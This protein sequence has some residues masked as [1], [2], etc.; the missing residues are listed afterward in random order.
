M[1][2]RTSSWLRDDLSPSRGGSGGPEPHSASRTRRALGSPSAIEPKHSDRGQGTRRRPSCSPSAPK[3]RTAPKSHS[4][5]KTICKVMIMSED[6]KNQPTASSDAASGGGVNAGAAAIG[7]VF[8]FLAG[9]ALMWGYD[10]WR[11]R[12]GGMAASGEGAS[13]AAWDDSESPIP[14]TSKDPMWGKRDAP[15]TVV[16]YSDFQCPFCSRVEPTIDQVRTTYGPDKVRM[17]WKN[18]PLP[19]HQNAKPAAEAAQGVFAMAGNDAFWKFHD[20]AFKNQSAL[21]EDSFV[22]WAQDAGVKDAAGFKA[23]LASHKWADKIEKD[24]ND[25]KSAGVQGTPSFFV[26]GVFING[27]QPFDAFKKTIDQEMDKAKAKL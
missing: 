4:L 21:N 12:S 27:A 13:A 7:F 1:L 25:G 5:S 20:T 23:G 19:F 10:Q 22:K 9:V 8:F 2:E 15:V 17:V 24:L 3:A 26:N 11:L 6:S 18:N 16:V 14:I